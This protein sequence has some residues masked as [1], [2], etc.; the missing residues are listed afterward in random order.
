[1]GISNVVRVNPRA[2]GYLVVGVAMA[3]AAGATVAATAL[4]ADHP[5]KRAAAVTLR[6]GA[7]P[8]LLDLGV[9]VDPEARALRRAVTL[10]EA[11]KRRQARP[12][13]E[14]YRSLEARI[15]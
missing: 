11:A 2:R 15:G 3:A 1:M 4:T 6:A 14:R 5:P 13:F 10:Y 7:P 8:L 9:R 12:I